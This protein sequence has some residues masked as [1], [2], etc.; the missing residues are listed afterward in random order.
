VSRA[1]RAA[2]TT[3]PAAAQSLVHEAAEGSYL[4]AVTVEVTSDCTRAPSTE[5]RVELRGAAA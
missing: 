5:G 4:N 2:L 1:P 3:R